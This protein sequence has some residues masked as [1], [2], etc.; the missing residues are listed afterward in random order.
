MTTSDGRPARPGAHRSASTLPGA[1]ITTAAA[2]P[3]RRRERPPRARVVAADAARS[4]SFSGTVG[5][6]VKIVLLAVVNAL[7]VWAATS[8]PSDEQVARARRA[9]RSRRPAIDASTSSQPRRCRSSSWSRARSSWSRS[10]SIPIVYTSTSPSRTTRPATSSRR[11]RR[12]RDQGTTRSRSRPNGS[13]Y[14]M[15]PARDADGKL[16][17][18]LVDD[19]TGK[20][21]VGTQDGLKPLP[22]ATCS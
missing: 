6:V 1:M 12:S 15:A 20:T 4:P 2:E 19:A 21:Y 13:T 17:L 16:V 18:I 9:R 8:S 10:R 3:H 5:L 7:A 22:Q 14:T 11:A